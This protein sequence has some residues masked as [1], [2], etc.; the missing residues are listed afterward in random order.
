MKKKKWDEE[1][2]KIQI[3]TL[4]TDSYRFTFPFIRAGR[5]IAVDMQIS[6]CI[7]EGGGGGEGWGQGCD[8]FDVHWMSL[9]MIGMLSSV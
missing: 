1:T 2:I 6:W 8:G 3:E 9:K 7:G 5:L 4:K